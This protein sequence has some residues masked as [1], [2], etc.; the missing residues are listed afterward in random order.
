MP[1]L[2]ANSSASVEVMLTA[3]CK[4]FLIEFKYESICTIDIAILFLIL[5]LETTMT[6]LELDEALRTMSSS[7]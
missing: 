5:A 4:V 2:I 3:W 7:L 6:E 1:H